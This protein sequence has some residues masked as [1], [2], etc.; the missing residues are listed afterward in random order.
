MTGTGSYRSLKKFQ[1]KFSTSTA[2]ITDW[3]HNLLEQKLS[4]GDPTTKRD[5]LRIPV[6]A[7]AQHRGSNHKEGCG[8]SR[9]LELD[10]LYTKMY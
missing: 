2:G 10:R 5:V 3:A 4:I 6:R 7:K 9:E 8:R 1:P